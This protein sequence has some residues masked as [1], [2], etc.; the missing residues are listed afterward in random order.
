MAT[1]TGVVEAVSGKD[2]NIKSGPRAGSVATAYAFKVGADWY[3]TGFKSLV[4]KGQ[5]VS[6]DYEENSYGKQVKTV[7]VTGG[8]S[9]PKNSSAGGGTS[10]G[11]GFPIG[12]RAS[13]RA[14]NRQNALTNAV[15][16]VNNTWGESRPP[17]PDD[18]IAIA[19][20]FEAYTTGDLE[21]AAAKALAEGHE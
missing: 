7:T 8:S 3:N 18:V 20:Q 17:T 10:T 4:E 19:R 1:A 15:T 16:Y 2:R 9:A 6:F 13:G 5:E 11:A 14:I 12:P 21:T